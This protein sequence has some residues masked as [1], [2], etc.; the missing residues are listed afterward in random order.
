[1]SDVL[2]TV[3]VPQEVN[4]YMQAVE[5]LMIAIH[6]GIPTDQLIAKELPVVLKLYGEAATALTEAKT[7]VGPTLDCVLLHARKIAF[8][9]LGK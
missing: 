9:L 8:S 5:D 6:K 3:T 4:D 1:M 7:E 2:L